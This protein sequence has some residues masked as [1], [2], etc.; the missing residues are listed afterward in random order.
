M[1]SRSISLTRL[2]R[3]LP[4]WEWSAINQGMGLSYTGAKG[5]RKVHVTAYAVLADLDEYE[6]RW[7]VHEGDADMPYSYWCVCR[8]AE[9]SK[10]E[11]K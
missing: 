6:S 11:N 10:K 5:D 9:T 7:F 3:D 4:D 8:A 2:K 1:R